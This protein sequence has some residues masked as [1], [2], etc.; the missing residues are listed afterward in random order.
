MI[1]SVSERATVEML[2]QRCELSSEAV[3]EIRSAIARKNSQSR[4]AHRK[5]FYKITDNCEVDV[6]PTQRFSVSTIV[7]SFE[8]EINDATPT[9]ENKKKSSRNIEL[10]VSKLKRRSVVN[11][12]MELPAKHKKWQA[13]RRGQQKR[14]RHNKEDDGSHDSEDEDDMGDDEMDE[15]EEDGDMDDNDE[16]NGED[17][18]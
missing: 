4:A 11:C 14:S 7:T 13:L 9:Y 16:D 8:E 6:E 12:I 2:C 3:D 15:D 5:R 1:A 10:Y 18:H 17:S